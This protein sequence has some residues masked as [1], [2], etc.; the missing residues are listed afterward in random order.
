[1]TEST[2][3][4]EQDYGSKTESEQEARSGQPERP[5][6]QPETDRRQLEPDSQTKTPE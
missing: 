2:R 3:Q 1:M 6:H 5:E 4:P